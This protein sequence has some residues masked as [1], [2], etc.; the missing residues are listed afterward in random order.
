MFR[1]KSINTYQEPVGYMTKMYLNP[2]LKNP[3]R[4]TGHLPL[5]R[6][7]KASRILFSRTFFIGLDTFRRFHA[8]ATT[9]ASLPILLPRILGFLWTFP[10]IWTLLIPTYK[11][12]VGF[13][14]ELMSHLFTKA[15]NAL[16]IFKNRERHKKDYKITRESCRNNYC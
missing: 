5:G 7:F 11:F 10:A 9:K 12:L 3:P 1:K 13:Y 15:L 14:S 16:Q 4:Q 8:K 6:A 2:M